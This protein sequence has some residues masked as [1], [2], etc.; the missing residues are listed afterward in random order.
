METQLVESIARMDGSTAGDAVFKEMLA[1]REVLAHIMKTCVPEYKECTIP[2]IMNCIEGDIQIGDAGVHPDETNLPPKIRGLSTESSSVTENR[3]FYDV[4]FSA[5][6]PSA[7]GRIGLIINVEAQRQYHPGYPLVKRAL[8]YCSRML[9]AQYG[10]I[11]DQSHYE[12]IQK[13]YSIWIC[14]RPPKERENTITSYTVQEKHLVGNA[15]EPVR[16]Y[17]LL[18]A[19]MI[20]LGRPEGENY[21]GLLRMLEVLFGGRHSSGQVIDILENEYGFATGDDLE[22][23]VSEMCNLSQG[24]IEQGIK[25]G[26]EQGIEQGIDKERLNNIRSLMAKLTLSA[27][28]AM[29]ALDI[30]AE[31]Q[32]KYLEMLK[33]PDQKSGN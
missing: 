30:P 8:Y 25:Q 5:V 11:F 28:Q 18:N 29:D 2:E 15:T 14:T 12:N 13:V 9:S 16:N 31:E 23:K 7:D 22:G 3:T 33:Q 1:Y 19:T 20:C 17:D 26:I 27:N 6:A 21:G 32:P 10:P 4:R 24:F